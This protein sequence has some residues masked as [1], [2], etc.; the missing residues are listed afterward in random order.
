[1]D[2]AEVVARL[3]EAFGVEP[4]PDGRIVTVAVPPERWTEL[5]AFARR[6][7]GCRFFSWLSAVDWKAEGLEV[8]CRVENLEAG[9]ALLMRT[10][11]GPGQTRC[12]SLTGL[13]KGADWM[14]RE[15]Y[16]M[17]GIVFTGHPDLRRILLPDDWDGHPLRKDY[18][19]DTPHPPYR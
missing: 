2:A 19:V 3:Q 8:L 10:R 5:A 9:V 14:E 11:L 16:D 6:T 15:C 1:M 17:F 18:A 12:P 7:L 13:W 4:T